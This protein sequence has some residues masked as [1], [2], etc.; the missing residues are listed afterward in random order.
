M[1]RLRI[2]LAVVEDCC[3]CWPFRIPKAFGSEMVSSRFGDSGSER[4][5]EH[6]I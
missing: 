4:E 1:G 3:I 5:G 2:K 6:V